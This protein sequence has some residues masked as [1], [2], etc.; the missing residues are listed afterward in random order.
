LVLTGAVD[1]LDL[2]GQ[3]RGVTGVGQPADPALYE[4]LVAAFPQA[5]L[6]DPD[7]DTSP[8]AAAALSGAEQ[9]ITWDAPIHS[10]EDIAALS[11]RP[12]MVNIKPSRIGSLPK[13]CEAYDYCVAN[14]IDAYGGGQTELGVGR[15]QAQYLAALFHP[16]APNDLA[17]GGYN[18][19]DPP[20]G[21]PRSPLVADFSAPG[22][23]WPGVE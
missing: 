22:F 23:R 21:L 8:D 1:T 12:R 5:W 2:K 4:R 7:L 6:E 11:V 16:D 3:Y 19:P 9:R 14:G 17:P 15:G 20:A 18:S 13:L 10:V